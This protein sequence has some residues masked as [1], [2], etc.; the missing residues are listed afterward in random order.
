M[1]ALKEEVELL[2]KSKEVG[3]VIKFA[4]GDMEYS[5]LLDAQEVPDNS[6]ISMGLDAVCL[7]NGAKS[8]IRIKAT[9]DHLEELTRSLTLEVEQMREEIKQ[10][11]SQVQAAARGAS[12]KTSA[13][14]AKKSGKAAPASKKAKAAAPAPREEEEEVAEDVDDIDVDGGEDNSSNIVAAIQN[15]AIN[16]ITGAFTHRAVGLFVI[17][18]AAIY[19]K[20]DNMSV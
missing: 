17:A 4:V 19:F 10:L 9:F 14:G 16:L 7:E 20:G 3:V 2:V 8:D 5:A 18:S 12:K 15:A 1:Q 6:S 11:T 13:G